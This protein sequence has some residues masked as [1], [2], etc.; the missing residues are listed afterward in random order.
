LRGLSVRVL[1]IA[2]MTLGPRMPLPADAS[3]VEL[4]FSTQPRL[5]LKDVSGTTSTWTVTSDGLVSS[6]VGAKPRP[7]ASV[8]LADRGV[9]PTLP[10][11][12]RG[13]CGFSLRMRRDAHGV[14]RLEVSRPRAKSFALDTRYGA[15]LRGLPFP[16]GRPA[17]PAE[18]TTTREK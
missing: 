11:T 2:D 4:W 1:E 17:P 10:Q 18:K 6:G 12:R 16:D 7:G 14:W 9:E 8:V 15:G 5:K 3:R 13:K